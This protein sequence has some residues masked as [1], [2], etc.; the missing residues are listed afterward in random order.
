MDKRVD[1]FV[2]KF[3]VKWSSSC[4]DVRIRIRNFV[5][6]IEVTVVIYVEDISNTSNDPVSAGVA[7]S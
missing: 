4:V 6:P 2:D 5:D 1:S 3:L 7:S